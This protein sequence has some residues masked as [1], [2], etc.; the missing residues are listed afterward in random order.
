MWQMSIEPHP[1]TGLQTAGVGQRLLLGQ[2]ETFRK[3]VDRPALG[4]VPARETVPLPGRGGVGLIA[5]MDATGSATTRST[6][7]GSVTST[8]AARARAP[9]AA[10]FSAVVVAASALWTSPGSPPAPP[11][12]N[13]RVGARGGCVDAHH[14]AGW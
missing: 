8:A 9:P 13:H 5:V 7:A 6:P 4:T 11:A 2:R 14:H 3:R 10:I 12:P 1:H